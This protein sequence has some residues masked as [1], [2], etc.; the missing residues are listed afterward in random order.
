MIIEYSH[1]EPVADP[2]GGAEGAMPPP[3]GPVKIGH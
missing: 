3:P 1:A 2:G